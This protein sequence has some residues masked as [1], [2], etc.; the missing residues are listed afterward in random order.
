MKRFGIL[1]MVL[2]SLLAFSLNACAAD[3]VVE[4]G[5]T[6][7]IHYTLTVDGE[8]VDSTLER[9]P[10]EFAFGIDPI[11]PGMQAA[12]EGRKAGNKDQITL[13]PAEGFGEIIAEAVVEVPK[14][15]F[16][17][18]EV[19]AGMVVTSVD[20]EGKPIR[21]TVKEIR[22][23]VVLLDFNHPFA[24]KELIIDFEIIEVA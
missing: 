1:S 6:V 18:G 14:G 3:K 12:L 22:D 17:N 10:L 9:E 21:A 8:V 20:P 15:Q 4:K 16:E 19:E 11:M 23:E 13:S 2:F 7:K 5:K 24:G